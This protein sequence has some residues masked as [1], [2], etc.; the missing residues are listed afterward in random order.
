MT[1]A[2]QKTGEQTTQ[3]KETHGFQTEVKQLLDLMVH[4]LYSHKEIFLR[5]L[6]SNASDALDKLR[7]KVLSDDSYAKYLNDQDYHIRVET[8]KTNRLLIIEDNGIGMNRAEVM[9]NLGTIAKSGTKAFINS[10]SGDNAKDTQLIGKFGVGFYSVFMV[11]D[12]VVVET[13]R[14][15]E[16]SS[17]A[18]R[19]QST[20]DGNYSLE[21]ITKSTIGTRIIISLKE[22]EDEYLDNWKIKNIIS[23]YSDHIAFPVLMKKEPVETKA[24]DNDSKEN[25]TVIE[26]DETINKA[27]ALWLRSKKEVTTEEYTEFYKH[28]SHDYQAPLLN[29]HSKVE[30]KLEYTCL[31]FIPSAAP[32]NLMQRDQNYGLKLYVNR[33]FIM[34]DVSQFLP[35]YLRF[36]RGIVDSNE[37]PLNVSRE[38]LQHSKAVDSMK[39]ALTKKILDQLETLAKDNPAE[40]KKFWSVFGNVLKEGPAEDYANRDRIAKLLRFASTQSESAEQDVTLDDYIS[41]MQKGQDKIYY[42]TAETF[43]QA[44]NSPYLETLREKNIEVILL[45]D[46]IDEWLMSNLH[47]YQGK[48]F[49]AI[50]KGDLDLGELADKE[51]KEAQEQQKTEYKDFL[52]KIKA[53][54]GDKVKEVKISS[55]LKDSPACIVADQYDMGFQLQRLMKAAGQAMPPSLPVF[56]INVKHPIVSKLTTQQDQS[57]FDDWVNILFDQAILAESGTLDDPASFVNRLNK[58]LLEV[59]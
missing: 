15:N 51:D 38:I 30:G 44:K 3:S 6:V 13:R 27:T 54:L 53:T 45:F 12:N 24:E 10:L 37:L 17:Q 59:M 22:E 18:V 16:D 57:K 32:F 25:E 56:E 36:V 58:M 52:D 28:I 8:D 34:D 1:A 14:A 9:E 5:E 39:N 11:A 7:F 43:A 49:Q 31:L 2:S 42:I 50:N 19:W 20:G 47:E 40:Y 29:I 48:S 55:R 4:S 23:K 21:N 46:R 26:E 33:V 41:R 35:S